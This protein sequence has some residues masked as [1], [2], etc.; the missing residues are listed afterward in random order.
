MRM[1]L[2]DPEL[3]IGPVLAREQRVLA[4]AVDHPLASLTPV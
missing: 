1:P 4:V 2:T 3:T